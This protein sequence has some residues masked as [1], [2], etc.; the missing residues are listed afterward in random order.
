MFEGL[1]TISREN[2]TDPAVVVITVVVVQEN[3]GERDTTFIYYYGRP[4][5]KWV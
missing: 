4:S 5:G 1:N 2:G 3:R